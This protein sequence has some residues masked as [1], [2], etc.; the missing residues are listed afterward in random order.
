MKNLNLY[1]WEV[2]EK[3]MFY[4]T[5]IFLNLLKCVSKISGYIKFQYICII[6]KFYNEDISL[7]DGRYFKDTSNF[8]CLPFQHY[9][10]ISCNC[11]DEELSLS[12]TSLN[13]IKY[14]GYKEDDN[15]RALITLKE[16]KIFCHLPEKITEI[17]FV[18]FP[19]KDESILIL[20][21]DKPFFKKILT[22]KLD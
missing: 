14:I 16:I 5:L 2:T 1:M 4:I 7:F 3:V 11:Q 20:K 10:S 19:W 6:H 9:M 18:P 12:E 21:N 13:R 17:K 15:R 8:L 22:N